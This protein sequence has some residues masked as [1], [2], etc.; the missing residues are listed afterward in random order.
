MSPIRYKW[1][2][3]HVGGYMVITFSAKSSDKQLKIWL[4][5]ISFFIQNPR[6]TDKLYANYNMLHLKLKLVTSAPASQRV[7]SNVPNEIEWNLLLSSSDFI[8]HGMNINLSRSWEKKVDKQVNQQ[9]EYHQ[10]SV[11]HY[12]DLRHAC[13]L[14]LWGGF[15][16]LK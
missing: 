15:P 9:V 16:K 1:D 13:D 14:N 8:N 4:S 11:H 3:F 2:A 7:V 12:H 6:V 5:T 10:L